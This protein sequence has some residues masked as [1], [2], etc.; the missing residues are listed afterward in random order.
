MLTT[1]R[2]SNPQDQLWAKSRSSQSTCELSCSAP[3]PTSDWP[4]EGCTCTFQAH[5]GGGTRGIS[6]PAKLGT[7]DKVPTCFTKSSKLPDCNETYR[8][9]LRNLFA[10]RN[11]TMGNH[12]WLVFTGESIIP[13]FIRWCRISSIHN[14]AKLEKTKTKR[15][16]E[17]H[18]QVKPFV[19]SLDA[20]PEQP[21]TFLETPGFMRSTKERREPRMPAWITIRPMKQTVSRLS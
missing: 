21:D 10:P 9:W 17:G 6:G 4:A 19:S 2:S 11:E 12:C 16:H 13:E 18:K 1:S 5:G 8:G 20:L 14:I 7:Q 3:R 15:P